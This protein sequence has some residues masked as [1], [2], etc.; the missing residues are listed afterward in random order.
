MYSF[1]LLNALY[2]CNPVATLS[3]YVPTI[4]NLLLQRMQEAVKEGKTARYCRL[5]VHSLCVFSTVYGPQLL[6]D[7][8]ETITPGLVGNLIMNIWSVNSDKL[9]AADD[10][11]V[12]QSIVGATRLLTEAPVVYGRPEV[13]GSL[14]RSTWVM[15]DKSSGSGGDGKAEDLLLGGGD[16]EGALGGEQFEFDSAYSKLAYAT[17]PSVDPC[18][19]INITAAPG[20]F[21]KGFSAFVQ[22]KGA[23]YMQLVPECL[24]VNNAAALQSLLQ[25][26]G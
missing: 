24:G 19:D 13:W 25:Q 15:L 12:V 26:K 6:C 8:L 2:S 4:L 7:T 23:Q 1:R 10:M 17:I 21:A 3:P 14:L 5:F 22:T 20:Y 11:E 16:E 9:A 18:A